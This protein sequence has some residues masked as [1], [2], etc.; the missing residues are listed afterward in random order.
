MDLSKVILGQVVTEKA[1]RLKSD[2]TYTLRVAP[3]ATKVD[4][5]AALKRYY[6]VYATSV[7]VMRVMP[8]SRNFRGGVMQKRH[9]YKKVLVTLESKSKPLDIATFKT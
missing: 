8:K 2:R 3:K 7:R 1:E 5:K 4:I 6:D 9:P